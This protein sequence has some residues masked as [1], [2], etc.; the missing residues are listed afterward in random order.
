MHDTQPNPIPPTEWPDELAGVLNELRSEPANI[1]KV[2]A[3]SPGLLNAWWPVRNYLVNGSSLGQRKTE[4]AVL[5]LA[6]HMN[7][8]YEWASHID[9]ALRLGIEI[10]EMLGLLEPIT[11]RPWAEEERGL[12]MAVDDMMKYRRIRP[13][14]LAILN[15]NY[16]NQQ[17]IDLIALHGM[18]VTLAG[19][20]TTFGLELD[21][22]ITER[23]SHILDEIT[24]KQRSE[25]I[26]DR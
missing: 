20:V 9:Q 1:H 22:D 8:W 25:N 13:V 3:N 15:K 10:E 11:E 14:T 26:S 21:Q 12:I 23:V 2:M 18:Y 7:C 24:F 17:I 6:I 16:S 19:I 5:R 4:L